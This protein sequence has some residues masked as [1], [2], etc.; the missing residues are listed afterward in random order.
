M[1]RCAL[2][3]D[4]HAG[5]IK[6]RE[7]QSFFFI[8]ESSAF[9]FMS[10]HIPRRI[11]REF[12]YSHRAISFCLKDDPKMNSGD[13]VD[14]LWQLDNGG[15]E[16]VS[17]DYDFPIY[18][19]LPVNNLREETLCLLYDKLCLICEKDDRTILFLPCKCLISCASCSSN[20]CFLCKKAVTESVRVY[21]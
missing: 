4:R 17:N 19:S 5:R 9:H 1:R 13:L 11:A 15:R 18:S 10:T 6:G 16:D 2:K 14:K 12:G 8:L 7:L 20:I 3:C 21:H